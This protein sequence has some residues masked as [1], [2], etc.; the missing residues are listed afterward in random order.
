MFFDR[1]FG[2]IIS[3]IVTL[4]IIFLI[5]ICIL[6]L[7]MGAIKNLTSIREKSQEEF[8]IGQQ[9]AFRRIQGVRTSTV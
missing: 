4:A 3:W 8:D 9:E 1:V 2:Y 6:Y 5:G 7:G